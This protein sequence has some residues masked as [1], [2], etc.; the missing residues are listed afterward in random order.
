MKAEPLIRPRRFSFE[1]GDLGIAGRGFDSQQ[2]VTCKFGQIRM[3]QLGEA[4]NMF[5]N[6]LWPFWDGLPN[7]RSNVMQF[8]GE[9][10][11]IKNKFTELDV[12]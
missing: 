11:V 8:K 3:I 7:F 2:L 12:C 5:S 10:W 9:I 6:F 4:P 1:R